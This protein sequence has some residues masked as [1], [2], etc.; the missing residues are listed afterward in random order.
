M[1]ARII[2]VRVLE[3]LKPVTLSTIVTV[4]AT[5]PVWGLSVNATPDPP[6]TPRPMTTPPPPPQPRAMARTPIRA[7]V[8]LLSG[9]DDV[10]ASVAPCFD[11]DG[12]RIK[13]R[14]LKEKEDSWV[15]ESSDFAQC[16]TGEE[17][18]GVA[19]GIVSRINQ[20]LALYCNHTATTLSVDC[21]SW[22]SAKG[23]ALRTIRGSM[24]VNVTSSKGLAALKSGKPPLGSAVF[25]LMTRDSKVNE[26][27]TLH[28]DSGLS[29]SQIY[30]IIDFVGGV[31]GIVKA[32]YAGRKQASAVRQ[33]ANHY[34]HLGAK[35]KPTL[36][37]NPPT[38][39]E[40]NVFARSLLKGWIS[41]RL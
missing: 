4:P 13:Q 22:I 41:L 32:G 30:D 12:A 27:L 19:D 2:G 16:A 40:A 31:K 33:T 25:S 28:G 29:W 11:S 6:G 20:I 7:A 8:A 23:E 38:L 18:L 14:R 37:A 21:I 17:V 34:R 1:N 26:A 39:V 36:P 3:G 9:Q 35:K 5:S 24:S 10:L 15:L